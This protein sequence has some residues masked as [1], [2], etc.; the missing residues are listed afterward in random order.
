MTVQNFAKSLEK[1]GYS[2]RLSTVNGFPVAMVDHDY[3][4]P[5]PSRD[6]LHAHDEISKRAYRNGFHSEP[7]G[8]YSATFVYTDEYKADQQRRAEENERFWLDEHERR[9]NGRS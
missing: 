4:G 6:A 1:I 8:Y 9:M 7:R 5:Y 2:V 3:S